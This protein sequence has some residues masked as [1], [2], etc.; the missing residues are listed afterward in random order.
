MKQKANLN[1]PA[2]K[3][4]LEELLAQLLIAMSKTFATKEDLK[5]SVTGLENRINN[6]EKTLGAK[7]D[8]LGA[9]E[10]ENRRRII[11]LETESATR[12]ELNEHKRQ[13]HSTSIV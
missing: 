9:E 11:D 1:Q 13:G 8:N 12:T 10:S 5:Q 4:D 6:V 7:I 2:T 3:G